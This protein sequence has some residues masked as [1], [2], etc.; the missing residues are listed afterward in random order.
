[1]TLEQVKE[2][3][4]NRYHH[5]ALAQDEIMRF[6]DNSDV[7]AYQDA[8]RTLSGDEN[9]TVNQWCASC[10]GDMVQRVWAMYNDMMAKL[11]VEELIDVV[12][13]KPTK[14]KK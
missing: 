6:T 5:Q 13:D 2:Y 8:Y 1:M 14:K 10:V 12:E 3:L 7:L 4:Q 9:Y 11:I